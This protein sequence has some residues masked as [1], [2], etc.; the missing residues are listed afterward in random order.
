MRWFGH[1][2]QPAGTCAALWRLLIMADDGGER[3]YL[4]YVRGA[5]APLAPEEFPGMAR[6]GDDLFLLRS[7]LS[8]SKV[9]H[10]VKR[11]SRPEALL[12]APLADDPKFKGMEAGGA[13]MA[14][15]G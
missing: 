7:A 6:L 1:R 3:L 2:A 9:Y 5:E 8:R 13:E 4:I 10:S 14:A 12:V 15:R 11:A